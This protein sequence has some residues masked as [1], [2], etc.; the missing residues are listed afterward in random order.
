MDP[1]FPSN[2]LPTGEPVDWSWWLKPAHQGPFGWMFDKNAIAQKKPASVLGANYGNEHGFPASTTANWPSSLD[3][4]TKSWPTGENINTAV[5]RGQ[6]GA[7]SSIPPPPA[8]P[9]PSRNIE[10]LFSTG[11]GRQTNIT[12]DIYGN[13]QQM[14]EGDRSLLGPE[15]QQAVNAFMAPQQSS[16][17]NNR[18]NDAR[19]A[20]DRAESYAAWKEPMA[21]QAAGHNAGILAGLAGIP[22]QDINAQAHMLSAQ[23]QMKQAEAIAD[24]YGGKQTN[25]AADFYRQAYLKN[26][27]KDGMPDDQAAANALTETQRLHPGFTGLGGAPAQPSPADQRTPYLEPSVMDQLMSGLPQ[28]TLTPSAA[29]EFLIRNDPTMQRYGQG[30]QKNVLD[31]L[32]QRMGGPVNAEAAL[33]GGLFEHMIKGKQ[34]QAGPFS[35]TMPSGGGGS[36]APSTYTMTGP[37]GQQASYRQS[38]GNDM[39]PVSDEEM[40]RQASRVPAIAR[41]LGHTMNPR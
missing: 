15:S 21:A 25:K 41:L 9:A 32:I 39:W 29:A 36:W 35:M 12:R 19:A 3:D 18:G 5:E 24:Q 40:A 8:A 11:S 17:L 7:T 37:G 4:Y 23:A 33:R 20:M 27:Y 38:F 16:I 6:S 14:K 10:Q 28:G 2:E 34:T 31:N 22:Y 1:L 26:R 30:G 13:I